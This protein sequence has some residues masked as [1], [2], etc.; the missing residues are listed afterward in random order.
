MNI[1]SATKKACI[2]GFLLFL[3]INIYAGEINIYWEWSP[4]QEGIS[5]FRYQK[6]GE[7]EKQW[8]VVDATITSYTSED[9]DESKKTRSIHSTII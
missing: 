4:S 8:Q 1:H 5:F 7:I 9:I 2:L 6:D 3:S